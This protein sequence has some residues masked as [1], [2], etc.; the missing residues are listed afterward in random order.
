MKQ[1]TYCILIAAF[2]TSCSG[3]S[4]SPLDGEKRAVTDTTAAETTPEESNGAIEIEQPEATPELTWKDLGPGEYDVPRTQIVLT[5]GDRKMILDTI[6]N[7]RMGGPRQPR[8][9]NQM[10]NMPKP[11]RNCAGAPAIASCCGPQSTP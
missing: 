5:V 1:L 6:S 10:A 2:M 4:L 11:R 7:A 9:A 8:R 3:G